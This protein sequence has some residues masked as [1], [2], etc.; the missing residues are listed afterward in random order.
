MLGEVW[1]RCPQPPVQTLLL[2]RQHKRNWNHIK[3]QKSPPR[4]AALVSLYWLWLWLQNE[5]RKKA[6]RMRARSKRYSL[7]FIMSLMQNLWGGVAHDHHV[8]GL[9][10]RTWATSSADRDLP[11]LIWTKCMSAHSHNNLCEYLSFSQCC[12]FPVVGSLWFGSFLFR[13]SGRCVS[14]GMHPYF[15]LFT[16][17]NLWTGRSTQHFGWGFTLFFS[18]ITLL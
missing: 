13:F 2:T 16:Y 5:N 18:V 11:L 17:I 1:W 6:Q 12:C 8:V 14:W 3:K 9:R 4:S 10:G 15:T 7:V